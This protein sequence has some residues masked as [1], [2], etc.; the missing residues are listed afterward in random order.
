MLAL[1]STGETVGELV[2]EQDRQRHQLVG[3][4]AGVAEHDALIAGALIA[5]LAGRRRH[6]LIDL[7]RLLG[8]ER[9]DLQRGVAERLARVGVADLLDR[10]PHD[11]VVVELGVGRD[12]AGEHDV[13]ALDE[14]FAGD[15]ALRVLLE[16]GVENR[17]G[18]VIAHLVGVAFGNRLGR[19]RELRHGA[20]QM[21][22]LGSSEPCW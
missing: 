10:L 11:L 9:D 3:F 19:E 4:V 7:V 13:V 14:R 16:A 21:T 22:P 8:D 6:A 2:R 15:A 1:R 20:P 17:V 12:L 18:D 5:A